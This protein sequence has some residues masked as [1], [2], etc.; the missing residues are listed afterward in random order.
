MHIGLFFNFGRPDKPYI[1]Y[2]DNPKCFSTCDAG[3]SSCIHQVYAQCAQI[4][5]KCTLAFF[6]TLVA[7]ID[8]ILHM[9]VVLN[10]SKH[11]VLVLVHE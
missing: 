3:F 8:S 1:A 11:V 2:D 10:V 9:M 5:H 4:V 6:S 7:R